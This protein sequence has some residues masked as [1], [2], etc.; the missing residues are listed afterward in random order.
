[1]II[2]GIG[3]DDWFKI[4][5]L[6]VHTEIL[7]TDVHKDAINRCYKNLVE[8]MRVDAVVNHLRSE[9]LLTPRDAE[10]ITEERGISKRIEQLLN[11]L[12][13]KPDVAFYKLVKALHSNRQKQLANLLVRE[14]KKC[15]HI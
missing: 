14:G 9:L 11:I 1:M 2:A 15:V 13:R 7:M 3:E 10:E 8:N 4:L 5:L 6:S 12:L